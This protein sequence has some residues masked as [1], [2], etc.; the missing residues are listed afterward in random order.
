MIDL[1]A[2]KNNAIQEEPV[3]QHNPIHSARMLLIIAVGIQLFGLT[4]LYSTTSSD[5]SGAVL[6]QKQLVWSFVGLCAGTGIFIIGYRRLAEWSI[7]LMIVSALLLAFADF[8]CRE[9]NGAHRWIVFSIGSANFSIQP[10]E[11]A[12]LAIVLYLS[13]HLARNIRYVNN[14]LLWRRGPVRPLMFCVLIVAF[15][16][17]GKDLGVTLLIVAVI[18]LLLFV[19]GMRL[20][21]LLPPLL[22]G[23]P[24]I[25]YL[26]KI[27][28]PVRWK[29]L[30]S[31]LDPEAVQDGAGYQ[32]WH[33]LLALGSGGWTGLGFMA[34][35]MKA[36]YLPEKHNDFILAIVGEELGLVCM[37]LLLLAYAGFLFYA[38][39]IVLNVKDRQG[40]L[41]GTGLTAMII[42]QALINV[43]VIAGALPT[44]GMP[45]PFISYGGSNLVMCMVSIGLLVNIAL[46]EAIPGVNRDMHVAVLDRLKFLKFGRKT[47]HE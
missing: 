45:A 26:I 11:L 19:A 33:S 30:T 10:S 23:P 14:L 37:W 12:K 16:L 25:V 29:R 39:R 32:L 9:I 38:I 22:V 31:F 27:F 28:S 1:N 7:E 44:K 43:G 2:A 5:P 3:G 36:D 35:R 21:W 40:A 20:R 41:L 4:M 42:L 34:S 47:K 46:E 18:W 6:F 17:L 15:I 8:F 24:V 13:R